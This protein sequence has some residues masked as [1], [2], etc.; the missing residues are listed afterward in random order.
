MHRSP[1]GAEG[2][3]ARRGGSKG[4]Y[5]PP[6]VRVCGVC[7]CAGLGTANL[8]ALRERRV[9]AR[10]QRDELEGTGVGDAA[11]PGGEHELHL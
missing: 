6:L 7:V 4:S 5:T 9:V 11:G 2:E 10:A 1:Q 8:P 3:G